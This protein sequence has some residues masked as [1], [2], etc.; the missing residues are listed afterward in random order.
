MKNKHKISFKIVLLSLWLFFVCLIFLGFFK[1]GLSINQ[2]AMSLQKIIGLSGIWGPLAYVGIYSFRS[3]IFFPASVLTVIGGLLFGPWMGLALTFIGE[4]ISANISFIVGRYFSSDL[5]KHLAARKKF[6][7]RLACRIQE[8][9]FLA[10]LIMRLSYLPFD[11]VGYSSGMCNIKQRDFAFGTLI[12][13]LP[14]LATFAFLGSSIADPSYLTLTAIFLVV[15]LAIA[16]FLKKH[17]SAQNFV[18]EH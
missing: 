5:L 8:N 15:G 10:V 12:G 18:S 13:T 1:M 7:P 2:A 14:G 3:L 16:Y 11:L 17:R 6:V 9:G 4:N